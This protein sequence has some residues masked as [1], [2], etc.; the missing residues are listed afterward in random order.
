MVMNKASLGRP[1]PPDTLC[2]HVGTTLVRSH[3]DACVCVRARELLLRLFDETQPSSLFP[4]VVF[5][6]FI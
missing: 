6:Q 3:L 1:R 4:V 5:A 2:H